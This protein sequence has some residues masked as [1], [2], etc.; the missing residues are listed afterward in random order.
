VQVDRLDGDVHRLYGGLP[1]ASWVLTHT[2]QV[3]FKGAWGRCV[4]CGARSTRLSRFGR[5]IRPGAL[6]PYYQE[7]LL[8]RFSPFPP[9]E[10]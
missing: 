10:P 7:W 4:T 6:A 9:A 1:N 3:F 5:M 2:G 8:P